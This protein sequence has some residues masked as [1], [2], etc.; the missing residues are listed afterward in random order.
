M[1]TLSPS[2]LVSSIATL[3][4][5]PA[6]SRNGKIARLPKS[7]RDMIN[8]MLDDNLPYE[9]IIDE[10]GEA[11]EGLNA[12]NLTNWRQGGYQDYLKQ[13]AQIERAHAQMEFAAELLKETGPAAAGQVIQACNLAAAT[14]MFNAILDCG[15]E[16]IKKI[17]LDKPAAYVTLLNTVCNMSNSAVR[18][19]KHQLQVKLA[20]AQPAPV[21]PCR[22]R[23]DEAPT[24][25]DSSPIKPNQGPAEK[26]EAPAPQNICPS[27]DCLQPPLTH[28]STNQAM[29]AS[30]D[31]SPIK[32]SQAAEEKLAA[33][34][35]PPIIQLSTN[36][37]IRS[38]ADSSPI[39]PNQGAPEIYAAAPQI[40]AKVP[41]TAAD[42]ARADSLSPLS[43]LF[44]PGCG[45]AD[46]SSRPYFKG[47]QS[48]SRHTFS[49]P[50][51]PGQPPR[52]P[53]QRFPLR[54]PRFSVSGDERWKPNIPPRKNEARFRGN[55]R[56]CVPACQSTLPLVCRINS[57]LLGE[58]W[59]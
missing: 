5:E 31:S 24:S 3:K 44:S 7:A 13:Q 14:Q 41:S 57:P 32:P 30:G 51:S 50:I 34:V 12:Q 49:S 8:H 45:R 52:C 53:Q 20:L 40:N 10:L 17:L 11:G 38:C 56:Q 46:P 59:L 35:Q 36:P 15:D 54:C 48:I 39:K 22:S 18:F 28:S 2:K 27:A 4:P 1:K 58:R 33:A 16:A 55:F 42:H 29:N 26:P 25:A 6:N 43:F 47:F 23:G 21:N 9:V 19:E 37:L